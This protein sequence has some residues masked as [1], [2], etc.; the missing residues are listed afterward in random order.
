[1]TAPQ[2]QVV[3]IGTDFTATCMIIN[4]AEVTA[5]DLYWTLSQ[6]EVPKEQYTKINT[7]ALNVT[8]HV[9]GEKEEWLFCLCKKVSANV[10][11]NQGKFIHGILLQKGCKLIYI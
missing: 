11:L 10:V 1:M 5:D 4:T 7:T 2:P 8:I 9:S 6:A 3:E